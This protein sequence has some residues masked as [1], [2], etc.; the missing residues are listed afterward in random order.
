MH[1]NWSSLG[2]VVAVSIG[3]TLGIVIVFALGV[4]ALAS[5]GRTK[6]RARGG[7]GAKGLAALSRAFAGLCFLACAAA[8]GYGLYLIVSQ[9]R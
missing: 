1:L 2:E 7:A 5:A 9:V 8:V 4:R 3:A 6:V